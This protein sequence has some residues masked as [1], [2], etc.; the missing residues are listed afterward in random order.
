M[1]LGIIGWYRKEDFEKA[2]ERGLDCLEFDINVGSDIEEFERTIPDIQEWI[3]TTGVTVDAIGRWGGNRLLPD[4]SGNEEELA[5]EKRLI[6]GA[7]ELGCP[8]YITGCNY[9]GELSYEENC[10]RAVAY[11]QKLL[12]YGTEQG[13]KICTYN[14]DWNN[15]VYGPKAWEQIHSKLPSLGIKY[16]M[17][18]CV[19]RGDNYLQEMYQWGD[20]FYHLHLKGTLVIDGK[21]VEDMPVGMDTTNWRAYLG[22]LYMKHYEGAL[23]LEPHG[24]YWG[25]ELREKGIDFGI[26][27]MRQ[28]LLEE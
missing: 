15:F 27:Y 3:R 25:A 19:A 21:Y 20:R 17:S 28:L 14:C 18:H 4:G 23:S 22:I 2:K 6:K 9:V 16:D 24:R 1:K 26:R 12:D 10:Q 7:K 13:V 11:F 8:V 5:I